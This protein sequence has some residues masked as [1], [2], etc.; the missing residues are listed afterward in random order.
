MSTSQRRLALAATSAVGLLLLSACATEPGGTAAPSST[1]V[2]SDQRIEDALPELPEGRVLGTGM[3]IDVAGDAVLCGPMIMESYPPQ[4]HGV[5]LDGWTWDGVDGSETSGDTTW[6][7]Y[8]VY[9][10][11]DGDRLTVTDPP[12]M[13]ALYD[14]IAPEDP[15][16]GV[17][18]DTPIDELTRIQDDLAARLGTDAS[19]G[20]G[21]GYVWLTVVWDDGT[22]Q[23]AADAEYGEG[24]VIVTSGLRE[25]D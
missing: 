20:S 14:P 2:P 19:V 9:A 21:Q 10:T 5:P 18:G 24:V 11:Y 1:T 23:D 4:C 3:V 16:G 7:T 8:A 17:E 15:T 12:I 25:I 6:G 22:I 13:L